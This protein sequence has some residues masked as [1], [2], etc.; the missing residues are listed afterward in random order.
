[1]VK[2]AVDRNANPGHEA[3]PRLYPP[4]WVDRFNAWVHRHT[5]PSWLYYLG[6]GLALFLIQA[7]V[8]LAEG[9]RPIGP[10]LAPHAFLSGMIVFF[11]GLMHYLDN[12]ADAALAGLR[13]ALRTDEE[14]YEALRYRLIT[15]PSLPTFLASALAAS[16]IVL[17]NEGLG[18]PVSF[19][20]LA[21]FPLSSAM[22]YAM[23]IVVWWVWGA[24]VYHTVHQL[25]LINHMYTQH[26]RVNVFRTR[27]LYAFSGTTAVTAVSLTIPTY[28]WLA[29]NQSLRDP[30]AMGITVP[31]TALA[32]VAFFWPQLGARR[33]LAQEKWSMLDELS[34]RFEALI[35][36]LRER[37]DSRDLEGI[38]GLTTLIAALEIEEEALHNV[39]TWPWQPETVRY[40]MTALL[41][42][43]V[44][45][46]VQFLLQ[47]ALGQ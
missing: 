24:F 10:F 38:D 36:E 11:P 30:I 3:K 5:G 15:L 41:L 17:I 27:L 26:T 4:S 18:T 47:R 28:A 12:M 19:N 16:A 46:L 14:A 37:V 22:L 6:I 43:L 29:I 45:W 1:M 7:G 44:L 32:L 21:G 9:V 42:P 8:P 39:S 25:R 35:V 2:A 31:I 20:R 40:L 13:P 33:L 34:L 23:Y